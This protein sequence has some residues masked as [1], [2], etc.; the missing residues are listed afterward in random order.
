MLALVLT[1][2]A[3]GVWT[4][5][6]VVNLRTTPA[7]PWAVVAMAVLLW[8]MWQYAGG[9][10]WP[11]LTSPAR[12]AS[13]RAT[14]VSPHV[15]TMALV[16]GACSLMAL[17][18]FWIVLFQTGLMRGNPIPDLS[19]YPA[20][21]V[22]AVLTMAALV[23]AFVEEAGF[24][25]YLQVALEREFSPFVAIAIAAIALT[26][27]HGMTQGFQWPTIAFY[28]AVD[29]MLGVT[30]YLCD[31][32]WPG[33]A[34]HACGLLIFLAFVWPFDSRRA[35][36]WSTG[37]DWWF[38]I[39]AA[40]AVVFSVLAVLAFRRLSRGS[41]VRRPGSQHDAAEPALLPLP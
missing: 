13:L 34:V 2:L 28:L 39:H 20:L 15:F 3:S 21:T 7:V 27:G 35:V 22:A 10:W 6:L 36:V 41:R 40:Q 18:G 24:R 5:L 33:V 29:V 8:A 19:R 38:W 11:S 26:P 9:R 31:S 32:V 17:T 30:A 12:R 37:T 23:G 16:A 25:G 14:P 4:A 1:T